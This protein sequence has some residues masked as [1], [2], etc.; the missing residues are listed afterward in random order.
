MRRV[1]IVTLYIALS[2]Y[3]P[4]NVA[5][6]SEKYTVAGTV[7]SA[8]GTPIP[9][10]LV[11]AIA[12]AAG[13]SG[14]ASSVHS[15][16]DGR[17]RLLL[18]PG[19]YVI[20]AKKEAEGY[21]DP[22]FLLTANAKASFLEISVKSSNI[23]GLA[24]KLADRGGVLEGNLLDKDTARALSGKVLIR[25]ARNPDAFVELGTDSTGHFQFAVP[26]KALLII[27]VVPGYKEQYFDGGR[28]FILS[29]GERRSI[30][31]ELAHE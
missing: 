8:E 3:P 30:S 13:S 17:F 11:T 31:I 18:S 19:K 15:D 14:S 1:L 29:G 28:E 5:A 24:V 26:A 21:P 16:E 10:T 4:C 7:Q 23:E 9:N 12:M 6:D 20:R 27:A 22:N 25:D 2:L